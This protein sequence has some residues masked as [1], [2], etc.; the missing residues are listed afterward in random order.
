MKHIDVNVALKGDPGIGI[1]QCINIA[2]TI[3]SHRS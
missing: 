1:D 2:K 3:N